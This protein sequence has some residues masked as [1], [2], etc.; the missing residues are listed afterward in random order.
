[1]KETIATERRVTIE[2]ECAVERAEVLLSET[3]GTYARIVPRHPGIHPMEINV[4][5]DAG[6]LE[7]LFG[8]IREHLEQHER[9]LALKDAAGA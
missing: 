1:M 6:E 9:A 8:R 3:G 5:A 7:R 2:G 4:S